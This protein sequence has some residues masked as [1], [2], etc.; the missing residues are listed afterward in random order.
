LKPSGITEAEAKEE[1]RR[2]VARGQ[3]NTKIQEWLRQLNLIW[4]NPLPD[5]ETEREVTGR[6]T[7]GV[8]YRIVE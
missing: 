5:I 6:T 1:I 2:M 7:G 3:T 8:G 4:I